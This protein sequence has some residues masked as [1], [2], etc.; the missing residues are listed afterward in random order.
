MHPADIHLSFPSVGATENIIL[1]CVKLKGETTISNAA[2][3]PE[4][5]DMCDFL[6]KMGA[7]IEGACG[8]LRNKILK[9]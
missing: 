7:D 6:N 4:I 2:R 3:E 8:Q 9:G 1:S 5:A